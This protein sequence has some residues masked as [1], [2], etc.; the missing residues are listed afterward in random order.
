MTARV[1]PTEPGW[2]WVQTCQGGEVEV[3]RVRELHGLG[4]QTHQCGGWYRV[5]EVARTWLEP[6][7]P[8]GTVARLEAERDEARRI[9]EARRTRI[10]VLEAQLLESADGWNWG[11]R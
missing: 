10:E 11:A 7:A 4:L 5:E 9:A 1:L 2:W 8:L 6:V 3:V